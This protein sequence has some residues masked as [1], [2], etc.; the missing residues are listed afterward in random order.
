LSDNSKRPSSRTTAPGPTTGGAPRDAEV[1]ASGFTSRQRR[2][3][4]L[5]VLIVAVVFALLAGFIIT[6][7]Q[8]FQRATSFVTPS[9]VGTRGASST[10]TPPPTPSPTRVATPVPE[11]GIWSQVRAARLFDQIAHQVETDRALSP[12]AEVPLSFLDE[13]EMTSM[14]RE[15]YAGRNLESELLPYA[16]LGLVPNGSVSFEVRA[17]AGIY[18]PEQ[19]QLYVST[20]QPEADGNAQTLLAHAYV[21]ALQD[22][23]FDLEAMEDRATSLDE[24]TAARALIAGDAMLST[25]LYR[26]GDLPSTDWDWL[27]NLTMEAEH[28]RYSDQLGASEAWRHLER[29][30]NWEGRVFVQDLFETGGWDA[31]NQAYIDP[32]RSTEQILHP[33]RYLE[34]RDEP[35]RVIVPDVGRVLGEEWH[36]VVEETVGE[37]VV[38]LYLDGEL[39]EERSWRAGEGWD[40]DTFVVWEREGG[41]RVLV[42]RTIWDS[43]ADAVELENSLVTFVQQRHFPVR[44]IRP[45]REAVGHWWETNAG[46][47]HVCRAGRYVLFL[48]APDVNT[49]VN[50]ATLVP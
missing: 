41:P 11:K 8:N 43:S 29:F 36:K 2:V 30:P 13:Q 27:T 4:L 33:S 50:V 49:A 9:A 14:L 1:R 37:L 28:P 24:K 25:A 26:H 19:E 17:P 39:P 48:Q 47:F 45:P 40:G 34:E 3:V 31:L 22:Q 42:W 23:H 46:T 7:L 5:L 12:R 35:T 18:V 6:S 10:G 21:H 20:D 16:A 44:P 38:G 15:L 32:P